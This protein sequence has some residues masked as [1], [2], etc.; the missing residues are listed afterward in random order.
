MT[1]NTTTYVMRERCL[2]KHQALPLGLWDRIAEFFGRINPELDR[3]IRISGRS[4]MSDAVR[5]T[6]R[7]FGDFGDVRVIFVA[8]INNDLVYGHNLKL[9]QS[10]NLIVIELSVVADDWE[11]LRHRLCY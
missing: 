1:K 8:P 6:A 3:F 5:H 4:F 11:L 7:E 10:V 9:P 2:S